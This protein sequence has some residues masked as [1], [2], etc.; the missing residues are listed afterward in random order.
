VLAIPHEL[1]RETGAGVNTLIHEGATLVRSSEDVLRAL[2]F[3]VE[4]K[5]E[6]QPLPTDLNKAEVAIMERLTEAKTRDDLIVESGL[7]AQEANIALSSLLIRGLIL[8]RLGKIE[9]I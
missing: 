9:R 1:G 3:T 7:S 4:E 8:E 5:L 6:Q 2:G